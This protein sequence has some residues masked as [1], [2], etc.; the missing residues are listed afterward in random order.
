MEREISSQA[1]LVLPTT[2]VDRVDVGRLLR[3]VEDLDEFL[4]QAAIREPGT[5][6][7]LPRISRLFEELLASNNL[8]ALVE[9]DRKR[10]KSF[11]MA[12]RK[13]APVLH[14]SFSADPSPLFTQRLINWLR[15]EIHPL[16]LLHIGLQPGI[17]A[18]CILRTPNKQ[19]DF[20]LRNQFL[21]THQQLVDR[22]EAVRQ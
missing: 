4:V 5:K 6:V 1:I 3:E 19:F 11:L 20:S 15:R 16:I 21:K 22:L 2:V 10:L 9:G 13:Q 7:K 18:G 17:G 8:N 12:V 14:M